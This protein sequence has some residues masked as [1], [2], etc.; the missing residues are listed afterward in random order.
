MLKE[1][2]IATYST[3][4][5]HR[6]YTRE[7]KAEL[8]AACQQPGVSIAG[9]ASSH[10]MNANVLHRWLKEHERSGCHQLIGPAPSGAPVATSQSPAFIP[11]KLPAVMH[12]PRLPELK[13]E[14][15]KGA[16]SMIVTWPVSAV[17][18]FAQWATAILK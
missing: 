15:R 1:S 5:T 9:L 16:L 18:E 14:L 13:V 6:T 4:R 12:E 10:A 3:R 11:L 17:A 2:D 8:V 7:F